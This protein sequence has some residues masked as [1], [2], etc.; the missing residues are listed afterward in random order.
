[1]RIEY[2]TDIQY[3]E[4]AKKLSTTFDE[5]DEID[6]DINITS[7]KKFMDGICLTI[8]YHRIADQ[9]NIRIVRKLLV[10]DSRCDF[11]DTY[12][13]LEPNR[14]NMSNRMSK[15]VREYLSKIDANELVVS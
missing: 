6:G 2:L 13:L 15:I 1:M 14:I 10:T 7:P 5:Y 9:P 4:L 3:Y 8:K 11:I 12:G